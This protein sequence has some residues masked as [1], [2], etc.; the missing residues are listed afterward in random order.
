M[1]RYMNAMSFNEKK[2]LIA[3]IGAVLELT[4]DEQAQ[5]M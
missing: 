2:A 3:V 1:P 4:V 5:A